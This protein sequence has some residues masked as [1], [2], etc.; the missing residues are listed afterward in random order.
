MK[1]RH[2]DKKLRLRKDTLQTLG[3]DAMGEVAGGTSGHPICNE[4]TENAVCVATT[5]APTCVHHSTVGCTDTMGCTQTCNIDCTN[6]CTLGCP[7][8]GQGNTH[9]ACN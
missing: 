7:T 1:K 6:G 9:C 4:F 3:Q 2:L 8:V 5:L